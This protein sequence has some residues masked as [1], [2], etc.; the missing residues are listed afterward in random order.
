[1]ACTR[2]KAVLAPRAFACSA[3]A[4]GRRLSLGMRPRPREEPQ[5]QRG[6]FFFRQVAA[7]QQV[8]WSEM[9]LDEMCIECARPERMVIDGIS[10]KI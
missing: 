10:T 2:S 9:V 1:M 4:H 5:S 6:L 7:A 3:G 8:L